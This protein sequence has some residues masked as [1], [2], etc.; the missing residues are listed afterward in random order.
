MRFLFF[1]APRGLLSEPSFTL[2]L[3][4]LD[5]ISYLVYHAPH[6]RIVR[7]YPRAADAPETKG[8]ER[9]FMLLD[10]VDRALLQRYP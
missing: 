7:I 5:H 9:E 6:S 8:L 2:D 3:L 4:Y 1:F 10:L